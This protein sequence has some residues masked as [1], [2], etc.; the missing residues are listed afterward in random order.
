[1]SPT[2]KGEAVHL[3]D[4][5]CGPTEVIA[6]GSDSL[7]LIKAHVITPK[8]LVNI[9]NIPELRGVTMTNHGLRISALTRLA[10]LAENPDVQ[11]YY[12]ALGEAVLEAASPQI[13]NV[14]TL[15]GNLCQRPRCWYFRNG[16]GLL[17]KHS[18]G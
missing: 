9:K 12:A 15:G 5:R 13:R 14:A 1:V 2:T 4:S 7:A 17:L 10:N 6:G 18:S 11:R 3:L 16:Y 8:H